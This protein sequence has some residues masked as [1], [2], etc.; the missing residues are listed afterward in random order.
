MFLPKAARKQAQN[1]TKAH[2]KLA[3]GLSSYQVPYTALESNTEVC[4][5]NDALL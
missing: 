5:T 4:T 2:H 1:T 3:N